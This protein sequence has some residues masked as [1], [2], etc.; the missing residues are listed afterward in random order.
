MASKNKSRALALAC[1]ACHH[2]T[3]WSSLVLSPT[4]YFPP[5]LFPLQTLGLLAVL[6]QATC[7][8][9]SLCLKCSPRCPS[10]SLLPHSAL[11]SNIMPSK[12]PSLITVFKAAA[13]NPYLLLLSYFPLITASR[14]LV[15][16]V[17]DSPSTLELSLWQRGLHLLLLNPQRKNR[18]CH[19][20]SGWISE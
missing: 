11:G 10:S 17:I 15:Y 14:Y 5:L 3:S 13:P 1:K 8:L 6:N 2:L 19:I 7:S 18:I 20:N 16:L 9:L 4:Y 12:R